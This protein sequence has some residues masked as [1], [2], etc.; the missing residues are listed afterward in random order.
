M[1]RPTSSITCGL[2]AILLACSVNANAQP[3]QSRYVK[4]DLGKCT[5]V[6]RDEE[7]G[8]IIQHCKDSDGF[9]F[10]IAEGDL[11]FFLGYGSNGRNQRAFRQ[12]LAP[13][14]SI[15]DT[16]ELRSWI[17]S[18]NPH[19]AILRYFTE[20]GMGDDGSPKG[21]VLVV[22]KL[23]GDEACHMA[24]VDALANPN[25]NELARQVADSG[26]NFNC[27]T[28]EPRVV[29]KSGKSPM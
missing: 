1:N 10:Y 18:E 6:E 9:A 29:G 3:A 16:L 24:Y 26:E 17:G 19:A 4:F 12:T 15:N 7:S 28:D 5:V 2:I 8:S 13:F 20:S 23:D 14:N 21:Q 27:A 25:A 22:T 11:R